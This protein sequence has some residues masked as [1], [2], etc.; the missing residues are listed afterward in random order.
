VMFLATGG[1]DLE[2]S[3]YGL[4]DCVH[5][6]AGRGGG[7]WVDPAWRRRGVGRALLKEVFR[8]AQVG[9]PEVWWSLRQGEVDS[10]Y[11]LDPRSSH[12]TPKR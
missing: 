12:E 4:L 10:R 8:W 11:Y 6:E 3:A 9:H 5:H 1:N 7:M 2:G